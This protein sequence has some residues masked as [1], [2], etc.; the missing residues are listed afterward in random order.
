M[1]G[2][3]LVVDPDRSRRI[4][5]ADDGARWLSPNPDAA[6]HRATGDTFALRWA[7]PEG[8]PLSVHERADGARTWLWGDALDATGS[9]LSAEALGR[10]L[11][12]APGLGALPLLDGLHAWLHQTAEGTLLAGSDPFHIWPVYH[13]RRG[14]V[15]LLATSPRAMRAHPA[16]SALTTDPVGVARHLIGNGSSGRRTLWRDVGRQPARTVL[17]R[18]PAGDV[19]L[20]PQRPLRPHPESERSFEATVARCTD[21]F[22]DAVRRHATPPR[23]PDVLL[24]SG[25]LDSRMIAWAMVELGSP[26]PTLSF[27]EE[28]DFECRY[29]RRVASRLRLP[30]ERV[31][32]QHGR[33][34]EYA[35][36]E[37]DFL[38]PGSGF[39]SITSWQLGE[40]LVRAGGRHVSGVYLASTLCPSL[41]SPSRFPAGT[42]EH[43]F[44]GWANGFGVA[45]EELRGLLRP[46]A[47]RAGVDEAIEEMRDQYTGFGDDPATAMS[48]GA[49]HFRVNHHVGGVTWK[50]SFYSWPSSPGVDVTL[51]EAVLGVDP[52]YYPDRRLQEAMLARCAPALARIPLAA[53]TLTPEPI[54]PSWRHRIEARLRRGAGPGWGGRR[55]A[56]L[57]DT[58]QPDWQPVR[59]EADRA[60]GALGDVF[61]VE[62]VRRYLGPPDAGR[63]DVA[64]DPSIGQGGRRALLGLILHWHWSE[65]P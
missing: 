10:R 61:D 33:L 38:G 57:L 31:P 54:I 63:D 25:G 13:A 30:F 56:R 34:L 24:L 9:R 28:T 43:V 16:L 11:E 23:A 32:D 44:D 27:G 51:F 22:L 17:V 46:G 26:A 6:L 29:A 47:L 37:V 60:L 15:F 48:L 36:R 2:F 41:P 35:R 20:T 53:G 39:S 65:S 52:A 1:A 59:E 64:V 58:S 62:S 12:A 18:P 4:A 3:L 45:P 19:R 42:F 21:L 50:N 8:E 55:Y 5:A 7:A 40:A 14:D 49:L